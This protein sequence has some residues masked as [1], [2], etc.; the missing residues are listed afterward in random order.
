MP[1]V[2][3]RCICIILASFVP[4]SSIA[5]LTMSTSNE[6]NLPLDEI[7]AAANAYAAAH[8]IQVEKKHTDNPDKTYFE[9]APISL[10]PNAF[11]R[12]AFE[13]AQDLA[14][15]FNLL[16][17]R[18]SRDGDFLLETLGGGVSEADPYTA[19]LLQ[20]YRKIYLEQKDPFA[21]Q[22]DR[23]GI[24]RS[25]YMLQ[26]QRIKQIE[27][28]TIAS[29]FA[30]LS[31]KVA[32]LHRFLMDR[33][34]NPSIQDFMLRNKQAVLSNVAAKFDANIDAVPV[35]GALV[36]LAR[37]MSLTVDRYKERFGATNPVV[38][39]VVQPGESNTVDQRTLEFQL[40][41]DYGIP[42]L[43]RS[44]AQLHEQME[45]N[46]STGAVRVDGHEIALV[47]YR[48]GY[49]P[50]DYP[51]GDD[52]IEWKARAQLEMT[53]ATKCP[54]LGYH[55][56][57]TKKVQQ[58]LARPDVLERFFP[59]EPDAALALRQ[60]FAGLYSLGEDVTVDDLRAVRNVLEGGA[61]SYVLKPQREGG[62]YN[63]YGQKLESKMKENVL[64]TENGT[65]VLDKRLGEYILMERLFPP[66]QTA[67]LLRSG[68]VE[69]SGDTISELGCFG[70]IVASSDGE[71]VIHNEY[72][73]FLLRTK[74]STVDEGGV[75]SGFATLS[76]PYLC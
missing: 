73:G 6:W 67:V 16:V 45:F 74:F 69:G 71:T 8:G 56:A 48:A 37:A 58:A 42:V 41:Q 10:L 43:R 27:L 52:G 32:N 49:A 63:F 66:Q 7:A 50:T 14:P 60:V 20:L 17:D 21:Q 33:F 57:G 3:G 53:R 18:I 54:S 38:L 26:G 35:N 75:A 29:S 5:L 2:V 31:T 68:K 23:L 13:Q 65:L 44:L 47:Y 40:F 28:N 1:G 19:K 25:D 22:A 59:N 76:S 61:Q 9:C 4:P 62:G 15:A 72:A 46:A 39:F 36:N 12:T 55:L 64:I 34:P 11:P 30:S 24:H 70:C 51:G